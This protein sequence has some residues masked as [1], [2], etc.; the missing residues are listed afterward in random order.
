MSVVTD[1]LSGGITLVEVQGR[2]DQ[3]L[4]TELDDTLS[5]L[6]DDGQVQLLVDLASVDYINSGGL[7]SLV[8]AWR[9]ARQRDGA[10]VLC[11]LG[12][13]LQDIFEMVG[14]DK[15][16]TIYPDRSTALTAWPES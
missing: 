5:H 4:T 16:F 3:N 11:A 7:R 9:H 8:S 6:L 10:L 2:I 15:V 12:P 13:R 1:K 14:F